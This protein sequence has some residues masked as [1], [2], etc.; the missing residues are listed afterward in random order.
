VNI[1]DAALLCEPNAGADAVLSAAGV[2]VC[3]N[4]G[5]AMLTLGS[6]MVALCVASTATSSLAES[7]THL[8]M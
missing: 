3:R 7:G 4:L 5:S 8:V 1:A 2:V 6:W